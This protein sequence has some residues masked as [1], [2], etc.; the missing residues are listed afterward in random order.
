MHWWGWLILAVFMVA[1]IVIGVAYAVVHAIHALHR[2]STTAGAV[3]ERISAMG[4]SASSVEDDEAPSFTR[5]I[6]ASVDRYS[7]AHTPV[8]QR[9]QT[10]RERHTDTWV[11]WQQRSLKDATYPATPTSAD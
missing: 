2:C 8:V 10:R 9:R 7:R 5:P 6:T 4:Q 1:M 11:R 3:N